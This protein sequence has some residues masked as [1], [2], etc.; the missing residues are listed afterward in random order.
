L[1]LGFIL[2]QY[3]PINRRNLFGLLGIA[4][5]APRYRDRIKEKR[6]GIRGWQTH[7]M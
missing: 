2:P 7:Q 1:E 3:A 5:I 4:V 6:K